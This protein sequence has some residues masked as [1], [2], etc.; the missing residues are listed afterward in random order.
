MPSSVERFWGMCVQMGRKMWFLSA[1]FGIWFFILLNFWSS[2]LFYAA[3]SAICHPYSFNYSK[4]KAYALWVAHFRSLN[5][6]MKWNWK[7]CRSK[8]P[9]K[10]PKGV[11]LSEHW[12]TNMEK[13]RL[14][15]LFIWAKLTVTYVSCGQDKVCL[16]RPQPQHGH[17]Q[18][19]LHGSW[20]NTLAYPQQVRLEASIYRCQN[21]SNVG[22]FSS[23]TLQLEQNLSHHCRDHSNCVCAWVLALLEHNLPTKKCLFKNALLF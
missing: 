16:S 12:R 15:F 5:W 1:L 6:E 13:I 17:I 10:T 7:A 19:F 4:I 20:G 22:R 18:H 23:F 11:L 2:N 21:A 8:S 9:G 3:R 14:C